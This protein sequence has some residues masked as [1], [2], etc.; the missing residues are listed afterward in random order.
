MH[1]GALTSYV[2]EGAQNG[3]FW[4]AGGARCAPQAAGESV[5]GT[6]CVFFS[7]VFEPFSFPKYANIGSKMGQQSPQDAP[8]GPT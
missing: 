6:C 7:T 4:A 8:K 3:R 2:F 5:L 1:V